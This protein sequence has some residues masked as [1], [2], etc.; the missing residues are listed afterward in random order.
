MIQVVCVAGARPNFVKM[1]PLVRHMQ[2]E[3]SG[4][5]QTTL[6]HTGQQ[7]DERSPQGFF[8]E[9]HLPRP[10]VNLCVGSGTLVRQIAQ[11]MERLEEILIWKKP[12]LVVVVGDVD[13]TLAA[14]LTAEKM[15]V[16]VAHIEAGLRSFDREMPEET[17]RLLTDRLS[18]YLFTTEESGVQNLL[19]EGFEKE[20]IFMVGSVMIDVLIDQM[21]EAERSGILER[22]NVAPQQYALLT[23][24]RPGNVDKKEGIERILGSLAMIEKRIPV[25]FSV[26]SRTQNRIEEFGL[27]SALAGLKNVTVCDRL[28]YLDFL[29]LMQEAKMVLTDS[30]GIQEETTVLGVPCLTLGHNTERPVTVVEGSNLLI[31]TDPAKIM[32]AVGDILQG[33]GKKGKIP[34][35]WDGRAARRIVEI[36]YQKCAKREEGQRASERSASSSYR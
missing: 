32:E 18:D 25:V 4:Q 23:L 10:D 28:G 6:V 21:H 11:M 33:R 20:K 16:K 3:W 34:M 19:N 26:H 27:K 12:D 7:E 15:G 8:E 24:H 30:G 2:E 36:L 13:S 31:G 9:R 5:F 1:A 14:A 29:R 22:L 17:N 35:F